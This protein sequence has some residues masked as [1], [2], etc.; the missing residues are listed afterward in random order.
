M[1]LPP[2]RI[3][4]HYNFLMQHMVQMTTY[5]H[6]FQFMLKLNMYMQFMDYSLLKE[7]IVHFTKDS[8]PEL[9]KKMERYEKDIESFCRST[10]IAGFITNWTGEEKVPEHFTTLQVKHKLDPNKCTL[11][12]LEELRKKLGRK[13]GYC[14]KPRLIEC[15]M[16]FL[17][18][19]LGCVMVTWLVP[20]EILPHLMGAVMDEE[21]RMF[22]A[23]SGIEK[24]IIDKCVYY[25]DTASSH[26]EDDIETPSE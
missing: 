13:L 14:L 6:I 2:E 1:S 25:P 23:E 19:E 11:T 16:I 26:D 20:V 3:G 12:D 8:N 15:A 18:V 9:L 22:F 21:S 10:T 4:E 7:I 24:V 5:P 17:K